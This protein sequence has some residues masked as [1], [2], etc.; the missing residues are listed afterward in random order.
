[1][2]RIYEVMKAMGTDPDRFFKQVAR[3]EIALIIESVTGEQIKPSPEF[4]KQVLLDNNNEEIIPT[5]S[6]FKTLDSKGYANQKLVITRSALNLLENCD[7]FTL[8]RKGVF[9]SRQASAP[10]FDSSYRDPDI[11]KISN[12][13]TDYQPAQANHST[14]DTIQVD[15]PKPQTTQSKDDNAIAEKS[16]PTLAMFV[17]ALKKAYP[18][19]QPAKVHTAA[20]ELGLS[21]GKSTIEKYLRGEF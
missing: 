19:I 10:Y 7:G 1:M 11:L 9:F 21:I 3:G 18:E 14:A 8:T 17:Q 13:Y 12:I 5:H 16:K 6:Y 20:Q 4:W 2:K 15:Q